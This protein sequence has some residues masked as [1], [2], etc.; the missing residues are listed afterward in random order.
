M[1]TISFTVP[2]EIYEE[3]QA[4]FKKSGE[5]FFSDYIKRVFYVNELFELK[6]TNIKLSK[7]DGDIVAYFLLLAVI[8]E[9]I[10]RMTSERASVRSLPKHKK[11]MYRFL[12][13]FTTVSFMRISELNNAL[14]K[15]VQKTFGMEMD[16][17]I[18]ALI[19][20]IGKIMRNLFDRPALVLKIDKQVEEIIRRKR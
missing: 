18:Q 11:E 20:T 3:F 9:L 4:G 14:Q 17:N 16:Y 2:D 6:D 8:T 13:E 10:R 15:E 5:E 19:I 7:K 1:K 12:N